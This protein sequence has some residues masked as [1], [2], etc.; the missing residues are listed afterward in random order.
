MAGFMD[1]YA[2]GYEASTKVGEDIQASSA[3]KKAYEQAGKIAKENLRA[4]D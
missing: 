3:L 4:V 2:S 1:A